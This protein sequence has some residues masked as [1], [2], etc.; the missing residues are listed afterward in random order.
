[1]RLAIGKLAAMLLKMAK[2]SMLLNLLLQVT[3]L[4]WMNIKQNTEMVLKML[5]F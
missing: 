2:L 3:I 5:H 4:R 1:L